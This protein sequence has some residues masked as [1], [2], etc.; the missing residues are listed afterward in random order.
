[1]K[2]RKWLLESEKPGRNKNNFFNVE[3]DK[4]FKINLIGCDT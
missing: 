4:T 1:M 2:G 3:K